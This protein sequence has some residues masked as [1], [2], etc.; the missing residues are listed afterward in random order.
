MAEDEC[1]AARAVYGKTVRTDAARGLA[2]AF[3]V[4]R[5]LDDAPPS[6]PRTVVVT[7]RGCAID[8]LVVDAT[9]GDTLE[10]RNEDP[11]EVQCGLEDPRGGP[12]RHER[13][14]PGASARFALPAAGGRMIDCTPERPWMIGHLLIARHRYH[15]V[16]DTSGSFRIAG[17]PP[18]RYP[19]DAW[20][21][22]R[23][24]RTVEVEMR[25][26]TPSRVEIVLESEAVTAPAPPTRVASVPEPA[27]APVAAPEPAPA[28]APEP[29]PTPPAPSPTPPTKAAPTPAPTAPLPEPTGSPA[30]RATEHLRRGRAALERSDAATAV[31]DFHT[32]T[33]LRPTMPAAWKGLG[34]AHAGL[35]HA[36]E[37]IRAYRRYLL[38]AP[39]AGDAPAIRGRLRG[40]GARE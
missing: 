33:E 29:A 27:P 20:H 36:A 4:L 18:G 2:G 16:T 6:S 25:A 9:V 31:R 17:V 7:V 24:R 35:G 14:A 23:R 40:L 21:P 1:G 30:E 8:P 38:V 11:R 26:G 32:A 19:I 13:I 5:G 12:A 34:E 10:I 37:A 39:S 28:P 15:A 3:V 22:T